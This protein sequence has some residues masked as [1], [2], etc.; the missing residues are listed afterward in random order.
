MIKRTPRLGFLGVG[1]IGRHRMQ[2]LAKSG[3]EIASVSDTSLEMVSE[4]LKTAPQASAVANLDEML[5][6]DIDGIV[7]A[8]PSALHSEQSIRVLESGLPVFCQ[9]PLGRTANEVSKVVETAEKQNLLLGVDLSYRFTQGM[10]QINDLIAKGEIG[11]L[12]AID[13]VFHNAYGPDKKWFYDPKLSGG[14]CV[15]DLGVHLI[16]LALW[17]QQFPKVNRVTSRLYNKGKL[18]TD[19]E[20]EIEDYAVA[21]IDL[22][23]G[24]TVQVQC[25]WNLPL[26]M[27]CSISASFFGT[28]GGLS[29]RNVNGSF[30]DF[31]T[32]RFFGTRRETL[33]NPPEEWG[34]RAAI[35][36]AQRL[37][38][39][40]R[41]DP[42]AHHLTAVSSVLDAVYGR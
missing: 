16:D 32:E 11:E 2:M 12:Y 35:D 37:N 22:D 41:F 31:T 27:D 19:F 3:F 24:V 29:F 9:K 34:G 42:S 20:S 18:T 15:M 28:K 23:N 33:S 30:Y 7:I 8:T 25:S 1:W 40:S 17:T 5:Q 38:Q 13:T 6:Q 26:G 14:G 21:R 4:A 36:W 10:Q 39:S